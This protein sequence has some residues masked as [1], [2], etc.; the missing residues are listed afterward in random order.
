MTDTQMMHLMAAVYLS[1]VF[2]NE[3]S[4]TLGLVYLIAASSKGLGWL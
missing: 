1:K 4:W 2:P 3:L